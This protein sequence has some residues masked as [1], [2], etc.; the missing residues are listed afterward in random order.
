[1]SYLIETKEL[2]KYFETKRGMLHAVDGVNIHIEKGHTL[3]VVGE[4]GCGKSTLGR[5]LI[6]LLDSTEGQ[7]LFNGQD[8]TKAG[9]AEIKELRKD[10]QMIFQDP[11]SS[12]NPRMTVKEI[13]GEPLQ[14]YK[15][16]KTKQEYEERV[17]RLMQVVGLAERV[18]KSYPH[19]L[20]AAAAR[21]LASGGPWPCSQSLWCATSRS[22]R[23]TY[24]S[25]RRF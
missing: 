6:H 13:I 9:K 21:E 5:V 25:R 23:W 3:G 15:I 16:C 17:Q 19:E 11:Y 24:P 7:I 12:L 20:D 10:M 1:M 2:K 14:I 4:S 18:A 22:P 8:I